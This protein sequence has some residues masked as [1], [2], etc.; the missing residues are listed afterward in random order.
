[1]WG[2]VYH[3]KPL[4][5]VKPK[6][7]EATPVDPFALRGFIA[8][9]SAGTLSDITQLV[10]TINHTR[11]TRIVIDINGA[12]TSGTFVLNDT[13]IAYYAGATGACVD[14][15]VLDPA[16]RLKRGKNILRFAPDVRQDNAIEDIIKHT[17]LFECV[18]VLTEGATAWAFA[19]WE[20]PHTSTFDEYDASALRSIKSQPCWWRSSF[21]V[22]END[23][24]VRHLPLWLEMN[25]MSKGQAF[26]NGRN[27]GRYFTATGH[28]KAVGP[29]TRLYVPDPWLKPGHPNEVIIFD[30]HGYEPTR[31]KLVRA[32]EG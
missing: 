18:D 17:E 25:E 21:E 5:G 1:M 23:P 28:G 24:N 29:Q 14:R 19:K 26:I 30:E 11:K 6:K 2:H 7:Q 15:I 4:R 32:S 3:V 22:D 16:D 27:I 9:Q 8:G 13:P 10:W 12:T 31:V 20:P